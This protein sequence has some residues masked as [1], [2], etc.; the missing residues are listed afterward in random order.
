M[1]RYYTWFVLLLLAAPVFAQPGLSNDTENT[2]KARRDRVLAQ[3]KAWDKN[4]DGKLAPDEL[5]NAG[6]QKPADTD[7]D[8]FVSPDELVA[9]VERGGNITQDPE[10]R[11]KGWDKNKDGKVTPDEFPDAATFKLI[12]ANADGAF[13]LDELKAYLAAQAQGGAE[14]NFKRADK[15]ND[16][17]LT[18]EEL[19]NPALFRQLDKNGDGIVTLDEVKGNAAGGPVDMEA[20]F[21]AMDK[22][23]DG[24]LTADELPNP[25]LLKQLD[26]NGDGTVSLDEANA[27]TPNPP[28]P[29]APPENLTPLVDLGKGKYHDAVGCLYPDGANTPPAAYAARGLATAKAVTPLNAAGQPDPNGRVVFLSIGMSNTMMEFQTFKRLAD[30]HPAKN[31][32]LTIIDGAMGG[33]DATQIKTAAA[34]YWREVDKRLAAAGLTASQVQVVWLK[35]AIAGETRPFPKDAEALRDDLKAIVGILQVRFPQLKIVYLSSRSYAGFAKTPLNPEPAAYDSGFAVKW[36]IEEAIKAH[37]GRVWLGWGP[38]LWANGPKGR[39][40][41]TLTWEPAD[42]GPDGTH[43][44]LTG[45][46]K[47]ADL[48]LAFCREDATAKP[49]F[50]AAP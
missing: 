23:G 22:N 46:K 26:K 49:W 14:A 37:A 6:M 30:A 28:R 18:P 32:A 12:D 1:A 34:P 19:P 33:Q 41:D 24:K 45:V 40:V 2:A 35:E 20:R 47:I 15:N 3:L 5:P 39:A 21:K 11:F 7:G 9:F 31:R 10:T 4:G 42:F 8:G 17:R 38:Y 27:Y 50:L 44:S 25:A 29:A 48:L 16:G 43:P 36:V 13:T